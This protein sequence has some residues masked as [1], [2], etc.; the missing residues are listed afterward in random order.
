VCLERQSGELLRPGKQ[1]L[2]RERIVH[3]WTVTAPVLQARSN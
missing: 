1:A 2:E 3:G